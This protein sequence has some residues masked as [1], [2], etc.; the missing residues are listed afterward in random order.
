MDTENIYGS[1]Q[2]VFSTSKRAA[3]EERRR[4]KGSEKKDINEEK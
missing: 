3:D 2:E 1:T 4:K